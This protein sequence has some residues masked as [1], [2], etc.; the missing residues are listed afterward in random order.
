MKLCVAQN[1]PVSGDV[2][3]NITNHKKLIE[4]AVASGAEIIIFPELSLT[5]YEPTLAHGLATTPGDSRLDDF[6]TMSDT[7]QLTIGVGLPIKNKAS[8]WISML[9]FQPGKAREIYSKQYLHPDENAFF[10]SGQSS[11]GLL[12]KNDIAL[13]ICYELS[14]PEHTENAFRKGATVYMASVAK[15]ASGMDKA[16]QRLSD[17]ARHYSLTVLLSNSVGP[18]DGEECAGRSSVWQ[19]DGSLVGQLDDTHKGILIFDTD[20]QEITRSIVTPLK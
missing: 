1:R 2:P 14:V 11:V 6:Q 19:K 12:G 8:I 3:W 4:L 9:L 7:H 5:G 16:T 13:A 20:S 15:T 18:A 17:I 10:S